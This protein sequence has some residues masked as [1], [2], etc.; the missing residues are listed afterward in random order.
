MPPA[1]LTAEQARKQ[2]EI[3]LQ[4]ASQELLKHGHELLEH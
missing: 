2:V 3:H 1:K 4:E